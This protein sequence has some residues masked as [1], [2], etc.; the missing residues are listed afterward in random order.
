MWLQAALRKLQAEPGVERCG[1]WLEVAYG[2]DSQP[3]RPGVLRGE[4]WDT[5][6]G[7]GLGEWTRL[8][9]EPPLAVAR[10]AAGETVEFRDSG[11]S[12]EP[13]T[14]PVMGMRHGIW[15]PVVARGALRGVLLLAASE[16]E[17]P[18]SRGVAEELAEELALALEWQELSRLAGERKADLEF[19]AR[20]QEEIAGSA[21]GDGL[22]RELAESCTQREQPQGLGTVFALVG[23]RRTACRCGS[24]G[25]SSRGTPDR[26]RAQR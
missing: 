13:L 21:G 7:I 15:A 14:G 17:A 2:E 4:I 5:A 11:E 12:R 9:L 8:W 3:E 6:E 26:S 1:A 16:S 19:F 23:E 24:R 25:R 10:L 22:L 18:L 20:I